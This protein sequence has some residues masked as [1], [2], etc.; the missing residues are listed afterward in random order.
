MS[1]A[2][3]PNNLVPNSFSTPNII[4]DRLMPLLSDP[5]LRVILFAV[6]HILGWNNNFNRTAHLSLSAFEE[7]HRGSKGCGL[8]RA[9]IIKA[10]DS[11]VKLRVLRKLGSPTPAGQLWGLPES[12]SE[13]NWD[14]LEQRAADRVERAQK[15]TQKATLAKK[16][17]Q[18]DGDPPLVRATNQSTSPCD[19]PPSGTCHEPGNGTCHE[20][21]AGPC[22]EPIETQRLIAA[23]YRRCDRRPIHRSRKNFRPYPCRTRCAV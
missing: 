1:S 5:E 14:A 13:I 18:A 21:P 16:Q 8:G 2:D 7:G 11:L 23:A 22:D 4:V 12:D 15:R 19:E 17:K 6:R 3:K 10:L 20:P 9:A